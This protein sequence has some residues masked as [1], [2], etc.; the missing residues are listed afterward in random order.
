MGIGLDPCMYI[1]VGLLAGAAVLEGWQ[2]HNGN[3]AKAYFM[4]VR[5]KEQP[6]RHNKTAVNAGRTRRRTTGIPDGWNRKQKGLGGVRGTRHWLGP[7][8][9]QSE[10]DKQQQ[11]VSS[12]RCWLSWHKVEVL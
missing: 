2:P 1:A 3:S 9:D 11:R 5:M 12:P 4:V 8:V 10:R 6:S 7:V